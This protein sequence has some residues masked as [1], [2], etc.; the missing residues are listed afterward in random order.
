[1]L[2]S[3]RSLELRQAH[4]EADRRGAARLRYRVFVQEMGAGGPGVDHNAQEERDRFD[5]FCTHLILED[6]SLPKPDHVVAAYRLMDAEGAAQAG[7]FY[8][9]AEYDLSPFRNRQVLELGRSCIAKD[10]R[11]GGALLQLWRGIAQLGQGAEVLFGVA[12]FHGTDPYAFAQ[13]LSWLHHHHLAP[14]PLRAKSKT[15]ALMDILSKGDLDR[16][17]AMSQMPPLI[18]SYLRLGGV[19]AD[20]AFV[21]HDFNT[22]DVLMILDVAKVPRSQLERLTK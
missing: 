9:D 21:D 12:S 15:H 6:T 19:V 22:T 17:A 5:R 3:S 10:Y 4:S 14:E 2:Q 20:G 1:M 16:R 8:C 7:G 11:G 18:K 13:P